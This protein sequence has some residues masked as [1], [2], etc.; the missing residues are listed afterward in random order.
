MRQA[1][2]FVTIT[3]ALGF[4]LGAA[5]VDPTAGLAQGVL[6]GTT[7]DGVTAF[8]GVPFAAP[9]L[10]ELR[11]APP[12]PPASWGSQPR[13]AKTF[14]A[15]CTQ[16]LR[17]SGSGQWTTE[18]MSPEAPGVSEDCLF[19]NVWT[20]VTLT[21]TGRPASTLPVLVWIYG[22]GFNEGSGAVP[23]YNGA[24]LAKKG[25]VVVNLN[26]RVGSLGF[27]AHPDLTKEQGGASG[28]YGIEDQIAALQWV[29]DNIKAFG[30]D[31]TKVTIAGQSAGAMSVQ[32]LLVS[33]LAK[34]L[35]RSAIIQSP[36]APGT[37]GNY[38]PLA[39][40]EQSSVT[41]LA[42]SGI[43][44]I[45]AARALPATQASRGGGRGGLVAD[46]RVI[47][48][49]AARPFASDVP[50]MTG[51][52][53]NDLFVSRA[54]VT[55]AAWK[56][57]VAER[58]GDRAGEFLKFYPGDTD[59]QA[60]RSAQ[61]EAVDRGFNLKLVEWLGIRGAS[62]PV[63]AYLFTHVEPGPES[64]RYGAFHTSEVPYEFNTLHLSPGRTFTDVDRR[65]AEQLSSYVANF[66]KNGDP[67]GGTLPWWPA[68][69]AENKALMDLGDRI[70]V[71]RAVPVGADSV[72]AAGKPPAPG[73]RGRG[74]RGAGAPPP[75]R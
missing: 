68:M 65:L 27:M 67:N 19:L 25:L 11:W 7:D 24:N 49:A 20:P 53:L 44:S 8:F 57:E 13:S 66:V 55:A 26:Y 9:P 35:F 3:I 61:R 46:G 30:G 75:P 45:A 64:A 2:V 1:A 29:R 51:Y 69:T 39:T 15:A 6:A 62:K 21:G 4:G 5:P 18:F 28:N 54:P 60:A 59:D 38:T 23:V 33:P 43:T 40:A 48:A 41:A 56:P 34:D 16:T 72:I 70:V 31:P 73:G 14:G 36:A 22:G 74:T 71:S 58:Y 32:A 17:S 47:P 12:R 63:F 52:T 37:N 10:G 42:S 50:V